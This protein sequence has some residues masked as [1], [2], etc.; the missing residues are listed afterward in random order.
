MSEREAQVSEEM[1]HAY[2]DGFL[3]PEH[4]QAVEAFLAAEP[5]WAARVED[6]LGQNA[7]LRALGDRL[8]REAPPASP[9][10]PRAAMAWGRWRRWAGYA[11]A[12]AVGVV[13]G[14]AVAWSLAGRAERQNLAAEA[15]MDHAMVAYA[16][17]AP[18]RRHP[19]E[20]GADE[21]QH[22]VTW[23]SR[24]LSTRLAIPDLRNEGFELVGGRL[25]A[26]TGPA[27]LLMYQGPADARLTLYIGPAAAA[28]ETTAF[29]F[30]RKGAVGTF[31]W[32]ENALGYAITGPLAREQLFRIAQ[33]V[34]RDL[35]LA[36][37][38]PPAAPQGSAAPGA[39]AGAP[40]AAH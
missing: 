14:G 34:H 39:P 15:W 35:Q 19:V 38:A 29:Q 21:H 18:E 22:L 25:L 23:L 33:S 27:A 6:Y 31:Y 17:Y 12:A 5:E 2:V 30:E 32:V 36:A 4:R 3:D 11:A 40:P 28:P 16:V 26:T 13:V 10:L 8:L 7:A 1:I 9:R 24:R 20:V 37:A